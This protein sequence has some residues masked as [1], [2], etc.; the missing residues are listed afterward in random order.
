[1]DLKNY[2]KSFTPAFYL[3]PENS[4]LVCPKTN[5]GP[6]W[7]QTLTTQKFY[8]CWFVND[9]IYA[10]TLSFSLESSFIFALNEIP[11]YFPSIRKKQGSNRYFWPSTPTVVGF[12]GLPTMPLASYYSCVIKATLAQLFFC[13]VVESILNAYKN[14]QNYESTLL[15]SYVM[16]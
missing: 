1:M 8:S 3:K 14:L 2:Y 11:F 4:W 16:N 13:T 12:K 15:H 6:F 5:G 10:Q 7:C 9:T